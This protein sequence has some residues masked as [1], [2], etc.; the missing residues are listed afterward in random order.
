[1]KT[2]GLFIASNNRQYMMYKVFTKKKGSALNSSLE[3]CF[4]FLFKEYSPG[5][6][7]LFI[8]SRERKQREF[9]DNNKLDIFLGSLLKEYCAKRW[10][11]LSPAYPLELRKT[12]WT[13]IHKI[14][15]S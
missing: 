8:R 12:P 3:L 13:A 4:G 7:V 10:T 11:E 6:S 9:S 5:D 1:M 2:F 14:K 15:L